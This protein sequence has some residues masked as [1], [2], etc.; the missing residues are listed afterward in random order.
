[1]HLSHNGQDENGF[2]GGVRECVKPTEFAVLRTESGE[3]ESVWWWS[4]LRVGSV[5][6][7]ACLGLL[8]VS[9]SLKADAERNLHELSLH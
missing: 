7:I 3:P 2:R 9:L 1:M 6:G 8:R 4:V 5:Y